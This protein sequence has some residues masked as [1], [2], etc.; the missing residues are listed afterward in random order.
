MPPTIALI[1]VC[2][3]KEV[4]VYS[5]P[6][7]IMSIASFLNTREV[8]T[9]IYD[10]ATDVNCNNFTVKAVSEYLLTIEEE[11]IGIS[12]WDSILPKVI[13]A[14]QELKRHRKN[15]TIIIGGPSASNLSS[16]LIN[17]FTCFDYC[18]EGEGEH[19]LWNLLQWLD[20]D[21]SD[22]LK[23]SSNVSGRKGTDV[24][25]GKNTLERLQAS[26]IPGINYGLFEHEKYNKFELSSSRGCPFRCEFCS[27]NSTLGGV[28]RI[29]PL[30]KVFE[31]LN[32]L[33]ESTKCE[34]VNFVDDNFGLSDDRLKEFCH[35]F[36]KQFPTKKWACYFGLKSLTK[37]NVDLMAD[38]GCAGVFVGVE[39]GN[40]EQLV[41]FGKILSADDIFSRIK[42]A[43][44][45]FD[46]TASFIW[47][48][49]DENEQQ[50]LDTFSVIER[51]TRYDNIV[52]DFYQLSPLS[53]TTL[54]KR[55]LNNLAFDEDTISEFIFPPHIPVFSI[56]ENE[57]IRKYPTIFSA[58][59][60]EDTELFGNKLHM[61]KKFLG[62]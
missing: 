58:F 51:L 26:E 31:E 47:G 11:I 48:F 27:I 20:S 4:D 16:D 32:C 34:I 45:K 60:H 50:L 10:I 15:K 8:K 35:S 1:N 55:M 29:R 30:D 23:L 37:D 49:P 6:L 53:G 57:L 59:Y 21:Q 52:I 3:P 40:T 41:A 7:G 2:Y 42:Y 46:V 44:A 56:E 17:T 36:K 24:F 13:L 54:T 62:K 43:T 61:V 5:P 38:S 19:V 9:H 14:V 12:V 39:S 18:V 22:L 28:L 25:R 33:F